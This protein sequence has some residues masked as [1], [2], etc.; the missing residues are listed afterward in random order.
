M[1]IFLIFFDV[2]NNRYDYGDKIIKAV[3]KKRAI[4]IFRKDYPKEKYRITD[5]YKKLSL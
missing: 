2:I 5:I 4:K 1:S 3:S